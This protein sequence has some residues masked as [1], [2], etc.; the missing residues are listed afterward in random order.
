MNFGQMIEEFRI[1]ADDN[2][3]P[4]LF[5][6]GEIRLWINQGYREAARRSHMF[7]DSS[8]SNIC[9]ITVP[10]NTP[11]VMVDKSVLFVKTVKIPA[12]Q[13]RVLRPAKAELFDAYMPDWES[14]KGDAEA[15]IIGIN[16]RRF[17]LYPSPT[18]D[19]VL[20][21]TVCRLP[22]ADLE[23][24]NDTPEAMFPEE[25]HSGLVQW[26]LYRAYSKMDVE[27]D[28][29]QKAARCLRA[30]EDEFGTRETAN[31]NIEQLWLNQQTY[32]F[33][34]GAY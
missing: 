9:S 14:S 15:Y 20:K 26:A 27:T 21:L 11:E 22:I 31:A 28:E 7:L 30:F 24:P 29:D 3:D 12:K 34:S 16:G 5:S 13:N 1:E 17:Q 10:A 2:Q 18:V 25:Y 33:N 23:L 4:P 6:D 19:T 32:Q 8:T